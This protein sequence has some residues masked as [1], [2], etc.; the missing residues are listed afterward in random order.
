MSLSKS[1]NDATRRDLVAKIRLEL[2]EGISHAKCRNCRCM[3]EALENLR[4]SLPQ[5]EGSL[6]LLENVEFWLKQEPT[7]YDCL[8]CEHCFAAASMNL[9]YE[10][11]P[12]VVPAHSPSCGFEVKDQTWPPVPGEYFVLCEG[13]GCP[14]AVSTLASVGLAE[15][16]AG[17]RPK[18]L[19][20]VGKTETEN[21]GVDK[22]IKNTIANPAI[23]FLLLAGKD[24]E[25]HHSGRTLF[26][27]WENGVDESMK[28]IGSSGKRPFLR[29][30]TREEV[31]AFRKQVQVVDMIGCEDSDRIVEKIEELSQLLGSHRSY[32]EFGEEK[33]VQI[34]SVPVVQAK[35]STKVK[36]DKAGYFVIIPQREKGII[37]AEH[38]SY[39]NKL[40]RIIEGNNPKSIY[41]TIVENGWVTQ[42]THAAYLGMELTKAELSL[43]VGFKY[44]QD[45]A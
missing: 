10:A 5:T 36:I 6:D 37:T 11:F 22:V 35:E 17:M 19:C 29:N 38:Y 39:E 21:I 28:V 14:V 9:F 18:E 3:K 13:P 8:G 16:L 7:K 42:L 27:L 32:E 34:S 26:A 1:K 24:P 33:P 4:A 25:G 31:E 15:K 45:G 43:K 20:I 2:R 12:E 44:V 23:R 30:V 41:K 40:L